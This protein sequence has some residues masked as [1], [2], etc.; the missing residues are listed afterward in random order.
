MDHV[1][2]LMT[3]SG[4]SRIPVITKDKI[5]C[6]TIAISDI[7]TYQS[8]HQLSDWEVSQ[9][10]VALAVNDKLETILAD[11][12]LT[13]VMHKLVDNPFLPVLDRG[14]HFLGIITRRSILKA[15]NA[16]LHDFTEDYDIHRKGEHGFD[17]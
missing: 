4:Y 17:N 2:L 11:A 6:G 8:E 10:D 16:L 12:S 13:E 9:T 14:K 15:V 3:S 7:M 1:M 5:Y